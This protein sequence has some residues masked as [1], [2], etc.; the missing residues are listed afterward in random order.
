MKQVGRAI[1]HESAV[2]H[3]TGGAKYVDD[4]AQQAAHAWPVCAPYAHAR[5]LAI[6]TSKAHGMPGVLAVLTAADVPGENDTGPVRHDEPLFPTEISF[7]NQPVL[8][9][10][11]ESEEQA[12]LACA[13]VDVSYEP[14][15]AI[16]TIEDAIAQ[17][18]YLTDLEVMQRGDSRSALSRATHTLEGELF[19]QGQEHFY[20]ETQAALAWVDEA[21]SLCVQSS[22]QHP[23]ETQEVVARV[24]GLLKNQVVVQC[25]RMGGGF[26]GKETQANVWAA[27]AALAAAKLKRPVGIRLTRAQDMTMTGKRHP[28]LSRFKVGFADDG[29]LEALELRIYVDGG[30]SLDLSSPILSRAMFHADNCYLL[31]NVYIEGRACRTHHVSH[32]AFRGFGG[33]QGMIAIEEILDRIARTLD[34]PPHVVRERNFYQPGDTT[35]YGQEVRDADRIARIWSELRES[36]EFAA[37]W[38][39]VA[40]FNATHTNTKRGLAIT[41]VKFGISFTATFFNQAGALVLVYRDGSVQVNHG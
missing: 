26:G 12:R 40:R 32:T 25:L 1:S 29:K 34:L 6:D 9:V 7:H 28:S 19:V 3:V 30:Y 17:D 20:L 33:P 41:P 18:A 31:P 36:S 10:V 22:T 15:P 35:H 2:G 21:D 14:L 4:L 5:V 38:D 8:W 39:D 27:V 24:M 13:T 11:A 37:R 23:A 16:L